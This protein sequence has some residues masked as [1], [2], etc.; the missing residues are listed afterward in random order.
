MIHKDIKMAPIR[1]AFTV[2]LRQWAGPKNP[3]SNRNGARENSLSLDQGNPR[4][5]IALRITSREGASLT[6]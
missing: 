1:M 5:Q 3:S 2:S 4:N 6:S